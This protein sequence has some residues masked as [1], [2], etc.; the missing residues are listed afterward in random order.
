MSPKATTS[1]CAIPHLWA[2]RSRVVALV[3]P[4]ALSS[5][6]RVV[7]VRVRDLDDTVEHR[8][9]DVQHG[10][11][12]QDVVTHEQ[13]GDRVGEVV[14]DRAHTQQ[15]FGVP[16]R[17]VAR[18]VRKPGLGLHAERRGGQHL[19]DAAGRVL[20]SGDGNCERLDDGLALHV[21]HVGAVGADADS[22]VPGRLG[23]LVHPAGW[24]S[25]DE[26]DADAVLQRC[27]EGSEDA[28]GHRPVGTHDGAVEV[29]GDQPGTRVHLTIIAGRR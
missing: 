16:S 26:D 24:T 8:C 23:N 21:V 4:S 25:G 7:G 6:Q 10:I 19:A 17:P 18:L 15:R 14:L 11:A 1:P 2:S 27:S 9:G 3:T 13:L 29:G 28:L 20:G 12:R 22:R 5:K